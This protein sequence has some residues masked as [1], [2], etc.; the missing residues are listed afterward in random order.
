MTF[1]IARSN[2]RRC[3]RRSGFTLLEVLVSISLV[4]L[5]ILGVNQVFA[6]TSRAV[7]AGNAL[8]TAVRDARNVQSIITNDLSNAEI[9]RAP[10]LYLDSEV[11][12]AFRNKE[13]Q[14]AD[15]DFNP[16]STARGTVETSLLTVDRDKNGRENDPGDQTPRAFLTSRTHRTDVLKFFSRQSG[17]RQTGNK[18]TFVSGVS[19]SE[20]YITYGHVRQP[21]VIDNLTTG[22]LP[23]IGP[24]GTALTLAANP[25]NFYATQWVLGRVVFLLR[26]PEI[27]GSNK[28][29][30]DTTLPGS[31]QQTYYGR[32]NSATPASSMSPFSENSQ[33]T[34]TGTMIAS[35]L[36]QYSFYDL[37]GMGMER[38]RTDIM[39]FFINAGRQATWHDAIAF[40]HSAYPAPSR[41]LTSQGVA[42]TVPCFVKSCTQFVVEYAGDF[43]RQKDDG[44]QDPDPSTGPGSGKWFADG[45][46]N[47][48]DGVI[49][50]NVS[51]EGGVLKRSI[52]WY[53]FPRDVNNDG[54]IVRNT[55]PT[56]T[57]AD[58]VPLRDY[59]STPLKFERTVLPIPAG[60][61]YGTAQGV[62]TNA[63]Y[64]CV[65][66][67][68]TSSYPR[69]KMIRIVMAVDDP[70]ARI[71]REQY[72]EYV[73]ELP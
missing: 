44:T 15:I 70:A 11:M 38:H 3:P 50:Y 21:A 68:D 23:G 19:A 10:F 52:R 71:A 61:D 51:N 60:N 49:D 73:V 33:S 63:H 27:S 20:Q 31:P 47:G 58:V 1:P 42:R 66:G 17:R 37:M 8:S 41:P 9:E 72:Y 22:Q 36:I 69:P 59:T 34:T 26:E 67:P 57:N 56:S 39:P 2:A 32:G 28:I 62:G 13:E 12:L 48:T 16:A 55:G 30:R 18:T 64:R 24:T 6:L 14:L 29:I 65:W 4:L 43:M 53:G 7:G 40:R 25:N 54:K 46:G 5:I 45:S 35:E